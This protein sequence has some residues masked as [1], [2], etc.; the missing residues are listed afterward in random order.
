[1]TPCLSGAEYLVVGGFIIHF[2]PLFPEPQEFLK[3]F[4]SILQSTSTRLAGDVRRYLQV[5]S[6]VCCSPFAER[7]RREVAGAPI[8]LQIMVF[9]GFR[10]IHTNKMTV[11]SMGSIRDYKVSIGSANMSKEPGAGYSQLVL[12]KIATPRDQPRV[13][14]PRLIEML[15]ENFASYSATIINGRAGTGK[16]V[17]AADFA[18]RCGRAAAWYKVDAAD[19]D[20]RIFYRY[21][22]ES[23][24][25]QQP[26][27][28]LDGTM[29]LPE[30]VAF[31]LIPLLADALVFQ[32]GECKSE[33]LLMVIE[34]L[35]LVYDAD[36][37]VPFF[38]RLLP[39]LPRDT[40]LL[41]TCR[42][43]P[44]TPLWRMR[45]KQMLRVLDEADLAFTLDEAVNLFKTHGLREEHARIA[46]QRTR[47]RAMAIAT[48]AETP[49][50][51]G[52]ALADSFM[53][54]GRQICL[55]KASGCPS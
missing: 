19:S 43:L 30:A 47:G 15:S 12:D 27:L 41:I 3:G 11:A 39:L 17:L 2:H 20:L 48:F 28:D 8:P 25:L 44:P 55:I 53:G 35:H 31:D 4:V 34:D 46:L 29:E 16:T 45:S 1:V 10:T 18:R 54:I 21:L 33:P 37:L 24:R 36:W 9:S 14:R 26:L 13:S 40:H 32:L 52:K 51:P 50:E 42:S 6:A 49:G 5:G 22:V 38:R 7:V 23:V